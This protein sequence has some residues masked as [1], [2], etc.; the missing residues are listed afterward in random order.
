[1]ARK[2]TTDRT[3]QD[4]RAYRYSRVIVTGAGMRQFDAVVVRINQF[5][6]GAPLRT[7]VLP[8]GGVASKAAD[9]ARSQRMFRRLR[10]WAGFRATTRLEGT[11]EC[12]GLFGT[13]FGYT[14]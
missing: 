1:M 2:T 9:L 6:P 7:V 14:E 3:W 12:D 13:V 4:E 8:T 11:R 10:N 5:K